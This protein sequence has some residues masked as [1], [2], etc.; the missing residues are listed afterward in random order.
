MEKM[1][2]RVAERTNKIDTMYD[3]INKKDTKIKK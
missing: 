3:I 2:H 1:K